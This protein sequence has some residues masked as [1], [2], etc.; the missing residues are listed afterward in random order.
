MS[1]FKFVLPILHSKKIQI[2]VKKNTLKMRNLGYFD[3]LFFR[4]GKIYELDLRFDFNQ[5]PNLYIH[6]TKGTT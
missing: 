3:D 6:R 5:W 4:F 2:F 1:Q